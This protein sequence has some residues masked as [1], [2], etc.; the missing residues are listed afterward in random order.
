MT[1]LPLSEARWGTRRVMVVVIMIMA[2]VMRNEVR[3]V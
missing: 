2:M 1:E 3:E